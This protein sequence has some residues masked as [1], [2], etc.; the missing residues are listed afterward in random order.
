V[1]ERSMVGPADV[2]PR[3]VVTTHA[4][5]E[6]ISA[7]FHT[8]VASRSEVSPEIST[9]V[10][11]IVGDRMGLEAA[12]AIHRWVC[13]NISYVKLDLHPMDD[14]VP[15]PA[16]QVL[17][18]RYGDCKDK[19]VLLASLLASRGIAVEPVPVNLGCSFQPLALPS[20]LQFDHCMAYLPELGLYSDPTDPFHD[21]GE[22]ALTLTDKFMVHATETGR[23]GRTSVGAAEGN[24]YEAR[25]T[26]SLGAD[27]I[28]TGRSE[29]HLHGR[30]AGPVRRILGKAASP[31]EAADGLLHGAALGGV[32][33]ERRVEREPGQGWS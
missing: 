31:G 17:E 13:R 21:L 10:A 8:A 9:A 4:D 7:A 20:P 33:H 6:S 18:T 12:R 5:W 30:L 23:V 24:R 29:L 16:S 22:L 1:R 2:C 3:F 11:G 27:G 14:W 26:A 19:Y 15:S 25:H 28:F 32:A